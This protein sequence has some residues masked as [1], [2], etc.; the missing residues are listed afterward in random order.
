MIKTIGQINRDELAAVWDPGLPRW[1]AGYT[2]CPWVRMAAVALGCPFPIE[3][4]GLEP[5]VP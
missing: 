5:V 3:L 4:L 2:G 1:G